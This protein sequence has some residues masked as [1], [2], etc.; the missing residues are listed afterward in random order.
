MKEGQEERNKQLYVSHFPYLDT[1]ATAI[2]LI[3]HASTISFFFN[4]FILFIYVFNFKSSLLFL[5]YKDFNF[6][7]IMLLLFLSRE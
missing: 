1:S 7:S 3:G 5:F 2:I 6:F 4:L